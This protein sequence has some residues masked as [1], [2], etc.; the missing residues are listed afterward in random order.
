MN[1]DFS[2]STLHG[3]ERVKKRCNLK[4]QKTISKNIRLALERGKRAEDCSSWEKSFLSR[5]AYDDCTAIAYN[6]HCYIFN[7]EGRCVTMYKLP[8]WFGKKKHF[9]GKERIRNYKKYCKNKIETPN[10]V[11]YA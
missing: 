7:R 9:D 5:E 1:M 11:V 2:I 4:N 10:H 3:I 8:T 6:D